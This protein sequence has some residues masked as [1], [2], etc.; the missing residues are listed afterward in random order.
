MARV[1]R[2]RAR[3]VAFELAQREAGMLHGNM[4]NFHKLVFQYPRESNSIVIYS[5]L[6][7]K[8]LHTSHFISLLTVS[9]CHVKYWQSGQQLTRLEQL[10]GREESLTMVLL[11]GGT[12]GSGLFCFRCGGASISNAMY[13]RSQSHRNAP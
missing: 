1:V 5:I 8:R 10:S 7:I 9:S 12:V 13:F 11:L 6:P 4:Y 3:A 2:T